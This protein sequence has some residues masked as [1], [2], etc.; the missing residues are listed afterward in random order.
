MRVLIVS[1]YF[2]PFTPMSGV[3]AGKL[4]KHLLAAG[5]DVRVLAARD[6][7][8]PPLLKPEIPFEKICYA[9]YADI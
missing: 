7:P 5:H 1:G 9:R 2:P 8:F 6:L 4:A 3:R